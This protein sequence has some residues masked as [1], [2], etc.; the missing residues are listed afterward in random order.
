MGRRD[1]RANPCGKVD[2]K[3]RRQKSRHHRPDEDARARDAFG[4]NDAFRNGRDNVTAR[5]K[6]ARA[7][8][9]R[10][11]DDSA[12]HSQ[13]FG[14]NRG[15][16]I[17]GHVIG[18][19]IQ[20][21]IGAYGGG[22]DNDP[23]GVFLTEKDRRDERCDNHKDQRDPEADHR[24]RDIARGRLERGDAPKV[25][26]ERF[27]MVVRLVV[28]GH[29]RFLVS[30]GG[31]APSSFE[32]ESSLWRCPTRAGAGYQ[33]KTMFGYRSAATEAISPHITAG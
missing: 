23:A 30:A 26:V 19:D 1:G 12:A 11:D 31:S 24:A 17:V 25:T 10:R 29:T 5:K 28:V 7:L 32:G 27:P 20:R 16:H 3:R 21:H 2:P 33:R 9:D 6:R 8:K 14:A 4:G 22:K 15:A 18:T 13:R